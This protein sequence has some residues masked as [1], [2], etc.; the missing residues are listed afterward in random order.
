MQRAALTLSPDRA[1]MPTHRST[2]RLPLPNDSART[3]ARSPN[4]SHEAWRRRGC[5]AASKW[6][7]RASSTSRSMMHS[8]AGSCARWRPTTHSAYARLPS[9]RRSSST[10][11]R[12]TWQKKCTSATCARPSSVTHSCACS[13]QSGIASCARTTSATGVHPLAC[14]SSTSS[15]WARRGRR[16]N[17]RWATSMRSTKKHARS[18]TPQNS[19]K[20]VRASE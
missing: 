11:R 16:K 18:S 6:R 20:I 4:R 5:A 17:S 7:A 9:P 13:R 10:T 15:T 12:R 14:S 19:S 1:S 8:W 2:W 3:R